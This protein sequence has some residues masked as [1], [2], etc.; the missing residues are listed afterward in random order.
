MFGFL[1]GWRKASKCKRA[2]KQLQRRLNLLKNKKHVISSHLRHDIVQLLRIGE[3]DR[4]LR[5]AHDLFLDESLLS[6]YHLL[7]QFSDVIL[8]NL[9][10]IR[11]HRE[12]SDGVNEAV[13]TLIFASARCGDLPE[14]R[15][16]R[17]LFGER[18]GKIF[19]STALYLLPGNRANPQIIE[20]LSRISVSDDAK[21]KLLA[22]I[23]AEFG[24][25]LHVLALEYTPESHKEAES[26]A[27]VYKFTLTDADLEVKQ[28]ESLSKPSREK[29]KVCDEYDCIEEQV[30]GK[31]QRIFRFIESK[32]E[33]R[34]KKRSRRRSARSS[35]MAKDVECWSGNAK[36]EPGAIVCRVSQSFIRFGSYQIHASRGKEDLEIVGKLADYAIRHHFP[37]IEKSMNRSDG[38]SFKTG[39]DD[40]DSVL[41]LTSNKYAAWVVE[42]SERT[43][44]LFARWQGVGFTHGVLN[45]DNMSILG[46]TIDYGPFGFLDAFDPSYTPNTTDLPG[47]R[48]CFAN[49]PDI[50]LWNI[51]QFAEA[52]AAAQLINEKEANYAM[53][54]YGDKF[55]DEYEAIMT[56]KLGLSKY[57]KEMI[58]KLL[59]NMAVD[60][61]DYTNFFRLLSNVKADPSTSDD[62][63]LNPLKAALLDI[64]KERKEEWI[65]WVRGYIH[66]VS[67]G[68]T[69][70]DEERKA[71]MDSVNPKYI[72]R[73][74]LCQSAIDAAEQGDFSEVNN[75]LRLMKRPY[76]EQPG[77]EKYAR[78][79]PAWAYRPG[80]CMLSCS[81]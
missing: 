12:V 39:D 74:Y 44:T 59:N 28:E 66:E 42:V 55:M 10:Y 23:A 75:L 71:R 80:V 47:R 11:R 67:G 20:K 70:S 31:D 76:D 24:L 51:A 2:L 43:A 22:E 46:Q 15:T 18:Y 73:N 35:P 29:I 72:L 69:P 25:S 1:F 60:K 19:V 61:V 79:P 9:S 37:R 81:S 41:D 30:V 8:L 63:L 48:Y 45:T 65:K 21:S 64:G 33:T 68:D 7:L 5:R 38:L 27:E 4:A 40:D 54:R 77:M 26:E 16:L 13:S 6:L 78:L 36:E 53:E 34:Q 52:L 56:K 62:E 58:S 3:R 32:E 14:L 57:N 50:A 49:Q 17:A